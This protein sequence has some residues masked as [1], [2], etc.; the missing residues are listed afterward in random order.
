MTFL[1]AEVAKSG[2]AAAASVGCTRWDHPDV[3]LAPADWEAHK[4]TSRAHQPFRDFIYR[5]YEQDGAARWI[6]PG[7]LA[8]LYG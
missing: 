2:Y 4:A 8:T 7:A 5:R 1:S 3:D 6:V